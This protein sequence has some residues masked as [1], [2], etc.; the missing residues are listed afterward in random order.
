MNGVRRA[1]SLSR[2][3]AEALRIAANL[4]PLKI[5]LFGSYAYGKPDRDS[6]VDLFVVME[7][8]DRPARRAAAVSR[9]LYPRPFPVDIMVRTPR[10]IR[11]RL[12]MGD[13][14]MEEILRKGR[15]LYDSRTRSRMD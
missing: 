6:D 8:R 14:F 11:R 9:L 1:V 7:T 13:F 10:E 15:V 12:A 2:I 5:I 3:R 4:H